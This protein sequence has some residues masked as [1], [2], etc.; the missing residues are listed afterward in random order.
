MASQKIST[1][2]VSTSLSNSDLFTF[3]VNSTNKNVSFS[4][5]KLALGV[6]GTLSQKGAALGTPVL[7]VSGINYGIRN[8]ESSKGV[9][10]S[11]SAQNGINLGCNFTQATT[12]VKVIKDL[13][14]AQ[15]VVKTIKGG[16][17]ISVVDKTDSIEINLVTSAVATKTK[18][19]STISDFPSAVGGVITLD[20]DTDY[21]LV[22]DITTANRFVVSRPNTIRAASSQMVRL[23][24]TGSDYMF[25]GT[26]P[27]F[28]IVNITLD[29]PNGHVFNT[30]ATSAGVVQMVES[31]VKSCQTL[32]NAD[33]NFITRFTNVA[34][35][36]LIAGG[37]TF[38]GT[39]DTLVFDT[40]VAFLNGGALIDLGTATFQSLSISGSF[41]PSSAAG[42]FFLSGLPNSG[43]INAGGLGT[44]IN[45]K[46]FGSGSSLDGISTD[47][48]RW[49]FL[50]NNS[51]PDTRP[52]GL[53]SFDA[54]ATTVL[55]AA[56]PAPITG[57]W[58]VERTSQMTGTVAGRL[59]YDGEKN[60]TLP[61]TTTLS[62]EPVSG[63]NKDIN[64]Y[65]AKNGA[66]I[67]NSKAIATVSSGSPKNQSVVWQD[68]FST[69]D[70]YEVWIESVDG[71]DVQVNTAKLRVN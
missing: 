9:I 50:A 52:D 34:F 66:I 19:I 22:E 37:L 35:E 30:T 47:D 42:T 15:Y 6:T 27:S 43:N 17:N 70:Y 59:T 4:D 16:S 13:N 31:N 60:S 68:S 39:H 25:S 69:G 45:N 63:T 61:I 23:T 24:Y 48:A 65:L 55:V 53:L 5:F 10:A 41:I 1:F 64:V 46:G 12:G 51:I 36:N 32:G 71:T 7:D 49:N 56:T 21:L 62:L 28:K 26:N 29:C 44:V 8:L 3:V 57:A 67:A 54:P 33:G 40:G 20:A 2:N 11:V 58:T 14:A 18:I 38:S